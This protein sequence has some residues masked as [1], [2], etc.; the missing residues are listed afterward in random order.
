MR[1]N[2][3]HRLK[4]IEENKSSILT[5]TFIKSREKPHMLF[6]LFKEMLVHQ[7]ADVWY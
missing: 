4:K 5:L 2:F 3:N 7:Y 6:C 1:L